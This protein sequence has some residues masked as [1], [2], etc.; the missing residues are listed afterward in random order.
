MAIYYEYECEDC[1]F[2]FDRTEL[3]Y[4]YN[5]DTGE[6]E[7]FI[8]TSSTT[9]FEQKHG[10]VGHID[11]S[12]CPHCD[13]IVKTYY[14][15][16]PMDSHPETY[17]LVKSGI[18]ARRIR[19]ENEIA[20][21]KE[22]KGRREYEITFGGPCEVEGRKYE[23]SSGGLLGMLFPDAVDENNPEDESRMYLTFTELERYCPAHLSVDVQSY[24]SKGDAIEDLT[25]Y[26]FGVFDSLIDEEIVRRGVACI[27]YD[28]TIHR[29]DFWDCKYGRQMSLIDCPECRNE[30]PRE[31]NTLHPCPKCGG[32]IVLTETINGD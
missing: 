27:D 11:E 17:D 7:E 16:V 8:R 28:N 18:S 30:I 26:A 22:I 10:F 24:D 20:E 12:C 32:K 19:Y 31:I 25:E 9:D 6:V 29:V 14:L 3:C 21:L 4:F 13:K 1:G 23:P 2:E 15:K 5:S